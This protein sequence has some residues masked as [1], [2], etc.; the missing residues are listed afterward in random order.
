MIKIFLV[1][2]EEEYE[3]TKKDIINLVKEGRLPISA[4]NIEVIIRN[5]NVNIREIINEKS[6]DAGLTLIGFN[7]E[8]LKHDKADLFKGF[9]G[10]GD[11]LFVNA[12]NKKTIN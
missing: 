3:E 2:K 4:K 12:K 5:P 10:I 8:H 7:G 11:V 6:M 1:C 9:D